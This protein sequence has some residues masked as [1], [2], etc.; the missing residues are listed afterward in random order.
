MKIIKKLTLI[1]IFILLSTLTYPSSETFKANP[2]NYIDKVNMS[3]DW[4][5]GYFGYYLSD[6]FETGINLS[7]PLIEWKVWD[8]PGTLFINGNFS[9]EMDFVNTERI[10]YGNGAFKPYFI[11]YGL[12]GGI[13]QKLGSSGWA[14][15][16]VI[17]CWHFC[18]HNVDT[19]W[20]KV[21]ADTMI[22]ATLFFKINDPLIDLRDLF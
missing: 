21:L 15:S 17:G 1:I 11:T 13:K 10:Q 19:H 2:I 4:C 22:G 7:I 16:L 18:A 20:Q 14:P 8:R 5:W 9:T 12:G 6:V 3:T